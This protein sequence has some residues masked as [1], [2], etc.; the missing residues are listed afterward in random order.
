MAFNPLYPAH[1]IERCIVSLQFG[2]NLPEKLYSNVLA[3]SRTKF[4]NAGFQIQDIPSFEIKVDQNQQQISSGVAGC[5]FVSTDGASVL[6]IHPGALQF[7]T[8]KYVRWQPFI[9]QFDE[10][11]LPLLKSYGDTLSLISVSLQYVDVYQ[12]AGDWTDFAWKELLRPDSGYISTE[13]AK[14][15][16]QWHAHCGWF[17]EVKNGFRRLMVSNI[18]VIERGI[19]VPPFTASPAVTITTLAKDERFSRPGTKI[20]GSLPVETVSAR[21][22][23]LHRRLKN[24][25]QAIITKDMAERV[26]LQG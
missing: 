4:A 22:D 10:Q 12:W 18:D 19:T 15:K 26:G 7:E 3:E 14:A 9:G 20:E 11:V 23:D 6:A 16:Y 1:S 24:V 13:A 21:L 5:N 2:E 25:L 17:E 8:A